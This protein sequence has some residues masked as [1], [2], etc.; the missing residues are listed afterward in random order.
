[1]A[2]GE[3]SRNCAEPTQCGLPPIAPRW[4]SKEIR[5]QVIGFDAGSTGVK[6]PIDL[7]TWR[8]S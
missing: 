8:I 5:Q 3:R 2:R 7:N 4:A 6:I 1:M